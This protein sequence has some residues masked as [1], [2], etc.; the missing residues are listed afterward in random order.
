MIKSSNPEKTSIEL[1]IKKKLNI[2]KALVYG[3]GPGVIV[4]KS[5]KHNL[6]IFG[7]L[8]RFCYNQV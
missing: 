8:L 5:R 4:R 3:Y 2:P 6:R 1:P 7:L